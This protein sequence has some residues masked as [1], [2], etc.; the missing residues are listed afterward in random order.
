MS[1][2]ALIFVVISVILASAWRIIAKVKT[3]PAKHDLAFAALVDGS[4]ALFALIVLI[5]SS[6]HLTIPTNPF[7]WLMFGCS[8][9]LATFGDYLI[10]ISAKYADTADSSILLPLSNV[11][12]LCIAVLFLHESVTPI[13]IV[14]ILAIVIG[15]I[16][17]LMKSGKLLI[18]RGITAAFIYGWV[19]AVMVNIDKGISTS[20]SFALYVFLSYACSSILM[21]GSLG[22][23][24]IPLVRQ[25]ATFQGWWILSIGLIWCLFSLTILNAYRFAG[26]STVV[27]FMR[28]F[29]VVT[30]VYSIFV[31]KERDRM[32]RKI[33]G[34]IIVTAG[35]IL[36]AYAG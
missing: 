17:T 30:T 33:I 14:A 12:V 3:K 16:L 26:V 2:T 27:P 36:L 13:K 34:S 8:I 19:N 23:R 11:W 9:I 29:I 25:E 5:F 7:I 18:N 15:S 22:K 35:A 24:G 21:T 32:T 28:L 20:F 10:L 1:L 31:Q 4:A 6:F